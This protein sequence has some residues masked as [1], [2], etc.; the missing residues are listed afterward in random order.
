MII[1]GV[2]LINNYR[3]TYQ[4]IYK[5]DGFDGLMARMQD[6]INELESEPAEQPA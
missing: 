4:E 3:S 5:K 1:E 6:K 2:S